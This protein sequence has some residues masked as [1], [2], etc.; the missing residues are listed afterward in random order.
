[1]DSGLT[2]RPAVSVAETAHV[3]P[4]ATPVR[5]A[6]AT[7]LSPARSVT[8]VTES[9]RPAGHDPAQ[10]IA[11]SPKSRE[12]V[13]DPQSREVIYRVIDVRSGRTVRQVPDE[14][15]LRVRAYTRALSDGSSPSEAQA[16]A[17][18]EA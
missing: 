5:D 16:H 4:E 10:N 8:A 6:V 13:L 1:M 15:L 9:A 7:T 11:T 18:R 3:R 17:D 12:F 14:A 2:I